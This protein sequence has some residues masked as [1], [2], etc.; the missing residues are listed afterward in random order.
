MPRTRKSK[1]Q[2][3]RDEIAEFE[4]LEGQMRGL[5][6]DIGKL[7]GKKP[8]DG[9]NKFKLVIVNQ[10]LRRTNGLLSKGPPLEGFSEFEDVELPSNSDVQIV[11]SQYLNALE[12]LRSE[13]VE[14][15][16]GRWF[17]LVDGKL[18]DVETGAPRKLER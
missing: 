9:I 12:A 13:N 7:T 8:H 15:A 14:R 18:S 10:L 4:T 16:L 11:L 2:M 17:W 5:Y 1:C 6:E 3:T